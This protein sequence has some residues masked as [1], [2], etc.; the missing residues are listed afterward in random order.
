[1]WRWG[2]LPDLQVQKERMT[3]KKGWKKLTTQQKD[4][5]LEWVHEVPMEDL[6]KAEHPMRVIAMRDPVLMAKKLD[7]RKLCP[8]F[9]V[10]LVGW[11][12]SLAW[13]RWC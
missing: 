4:E 3:N 5:R 8:K 13:P 7:S 12:P 1:M 6:E 11:R 10:G 2:T 9:E